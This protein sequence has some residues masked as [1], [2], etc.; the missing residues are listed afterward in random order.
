MK[1]LLV[2]CLL[3]L[4]FLNHAIANDTLINVDRY[5]WI[6]QTSPSLN[7]YLRS[8]YREFQKDGTKAFFTIDILETS[9]DESDGE[10]PYQFQTQE[11]FANGKL[12]QGHVALGGAPFFVIWSGIE[13]SRLSV[14]AD[15]DTKEY[16]AAS[17]QEFE[18]FDILGALVYKTQPQF[19]THEGQRYFATSANAT[20]SSFSLNLMGSVKFLESGVF[21]DSEQGLQKLYL[22]LKQNTSLGSFELRALGGYLPYEYQELMFEYSFE[23]KYDYRMRAA[24]TYRQTAQSESKEKEGDFVNSEIEL[25]KDLLGGVLNVGL[26]YSYNNEFT[27]QPLHGYKLYLDVGSFFF[28]SWSTNYSQDLQRLPLEDAKLFGIGIKGRF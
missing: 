18:H 23:E 1:K 12:L 4:T 8:Y 28:V 20:D 21:Y 22:S 19:E 14:N 2:S 13:V 11:G 27:P 17:Y 7:S 25:Y 6:V 15:Y 9:Y 3:T 26:S 16:A 10:P 24:T 5:E